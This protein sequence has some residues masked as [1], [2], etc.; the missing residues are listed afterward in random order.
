M[1]FQR[2]VLCFCISRDSCCQP[3][4]KSLDLDLMMHKHPHPVLN[5]PYVSELSER[6]I[7]H[8]LFPRL[9]LYDVL[10]KC[11]SAYRSGLSILT[12]LLQIV[13][14]MLCNV[15]LGSFS[16]LLLLD[17]CLNAKQLA[18][19]GKVWFNPKEV[20]EKHMQFRLLLSSIIACIC[21]S[22]YPH[23]QGQI[24]SFLPDNESSA[25][26]HNLLLQKL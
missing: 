2:L 4:Y 7:A 13:D 6:P 8:Q 24:H 10:D 25:L 5:F 19:G 16:L 11:P 17:Q 18:Y 9:T 22:K 21:P 12:V 3:P 1:A 26:K 15:N 14:D 23:L 20:V